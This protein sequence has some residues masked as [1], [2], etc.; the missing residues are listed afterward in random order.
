MIATFEK[1]A[2]RK[3]EMRDAQRLYEISQNREVML[4]YG[5]PAFTSLSEAIEEIKW[6]HTLEKTQQG[7]RYVITD[8]EDKCIGSLGCFAYNLDDLS[9]E[10]SYQLMRD[11]WGQGIM[12]Q[13]LTKLLEV[14]EMM[15]RYACVIAYVH[16]ENVL[17][18]H[19]LERCGFMKVEQFVPKHDDAVRLADCDMYLRVF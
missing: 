14:M 18:R 1:F 19:V 4:H 3:P 12:T 16:Q 9:V 10:I 6:F 7:F 8:L 15:Q 5:T 17:S 13:A 11:F 2:L